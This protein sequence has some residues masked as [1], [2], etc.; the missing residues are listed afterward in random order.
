MLEHREDADR[1][2]DV[3]LVASVSTGSATLRLESKQ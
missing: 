1:Y 3:V 2:E